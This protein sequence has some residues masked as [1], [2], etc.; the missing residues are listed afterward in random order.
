MSAGRRDDTGSVTTTVIALWNAARVSFQKLPV[1]DVV[2]RISREGG[3]SIHPALWF[4]AD[5]PPE[6]DWPHVAPLW[7]CGDCITCFLSET[8][9]FVQVTVESRHVPLAVYLGEQGMLCG[10]L[11]DLWE[12]GLE[13]PILV[14]VASVLGFRAVDRLLAAFVDGTYRSLPS[15]M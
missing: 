9:Q 14:D 2:Q 10:L 12:D 1:S 3:A 8:R 4:R 6:V 15:K 7:A 11:V 13:D 5:R